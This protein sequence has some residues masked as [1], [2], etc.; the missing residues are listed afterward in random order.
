MHDL[1]HGESLQL[2]IAP[3]LRG[4]P[5]RFGVR[6]E[7][8]A[9]RVDELIQ[10]SRDPYSSSAAVGGGTA[11]ASTLPRQRRMSSSRCVGHEFMEHDA[12]RT[13]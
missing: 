10:E 5:G 2:Q 7:V 11:R 8:V 3:V 4:A 13:G 9:K 1:R 6:P 12:L